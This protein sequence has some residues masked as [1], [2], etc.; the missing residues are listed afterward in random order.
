M[1]QTAIFWPM[2][3]HVALV[4]I[5]YYLT[6]ARR[7]TAVASGK[8]RVSQFR[9]NLNEPAESLFARNNL[10]NQFELPVLF[11]VVCL[12]LYVTNGASIVPL[13]L[14]WIFVISRYVHTYVHVTSNR[15][16]YRQPAFVLGF[17]MVAVLWIW[18]A[19]HLLLA[20]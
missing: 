1:N 7:R 18:L 16:R 15:I 19:L 20:V 8:A 11:H 4:F 12:A 6:F 10:V 14:A 9:E 2:I 13:V 17:L 5:V 3:A